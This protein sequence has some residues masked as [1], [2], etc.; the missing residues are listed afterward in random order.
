M[1]GQMKRK[2]FADISK[3]KKKMLAVLNIS[4][5]EFQE[6]F[7]QWEKRLHKCI[8]SKGKYFEGY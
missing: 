8:D 4:N 5:K 6:C 1:K 2:R 7:Q 3:V